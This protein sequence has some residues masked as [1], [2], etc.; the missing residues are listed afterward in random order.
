[1]PADALLY[2]AVFGVSPEVSVRAIEAE[3]G[4]WN[5]T[6]KVREFITGKPIEGATVEIMGVEVHEVGTTDVGGA[7]ILT[8]TG[9][10]RTI[11]VSKS[12]YWTK[13]S[14]QVIGEDATIDVS[15]IPTWMIAAG[16]IGAGAITLLALWALTRRPK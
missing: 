10:T 3:V 15:L 11:V 1:L 5:V 13:T 14:T 16:G 12:G 8:V 9:G 7:V 2:E 6:I 4:P